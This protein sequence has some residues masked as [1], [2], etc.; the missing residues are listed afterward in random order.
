MAL[1]SIQNLLLALIVVVPGFITTHV[2][3]SL[4]VVRTEI[5]KWRLLIVS[6]ST[7]LFV[8]S[9][10]LGILQL[11]GTEVTDVTEVQAVF[12]TP[13]FRPELVLAL[14]TGSAGMGVLGAVLLASNVHKQVRNW[15]WERVPGDRTR[16]FHE[17]WEGTLDEAA[18]VQVLTS[19]GAI[20]IGGL[21]QYSDDGKEKQISLTGA[22]WKSPSMDGFE[23]AG[24][25]IELLFGDDI[26]QI[27]VVDTKENAESQ[28]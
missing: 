28:E 6:L 23:D 20:V 5:S 15:I 10:F 22:E 8:V 17:P 18:R 27:T 1:G 2:A 3:V 4:G 19:D 26:Q 7:S 16:N 12:F 21:K 14:I 25:D 24:T 9:L 13:K 11:N